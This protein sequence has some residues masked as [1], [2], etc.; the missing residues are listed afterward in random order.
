M[1]GLVPF[2]VATTLS[3]AVATA[4][5]DEKFAGKPRLINYSPASS[6][7]Y[8]SGARAVQNKV[9]QFGGMGKT[10]ARNIIL[11]VGDGMGVST[12]TAARI[13]AGQQHGLPGEE[14]QL[15]FDHFPMSGLART[16][17]TNQQTPDSAGTIT[18]L[19]TGV[20]TRAGMLSVGENA[21]R[22]DCQSQAAN[23]LYSALDLAEI[24]GLATGVVSTARI[25]HATPAAS[26]A[27]SVERNWENDAEMSK[28]ARKQG[29]EDIAS[30][31]I[32]FPQRLK[33]TLQRNAKNPIS[34]PPLNGI[35]VV[36]G[37][38]LRNFIPTEKTIDIGSTTVTGRRKD[39]RNLLDEW[40]R[41]NPS[42]ER[43]YTRAQ[44]LQ[45]KA[46]R[47]L[48]LFSASHM[49]YDAQRRTDPAFAGQPSLADMTGVAIDRLSASKKGF[50]LLVE[51]GRI[52]HAHHASSAYHALSDT[53]A[54]SDAVASAVAKTDPSDTL[55][56]VT[57]DHSHVFTMAGYPVRGN[58]ILGKVKAWTGGDDSKAELALDGN[59][60]PY[61]TLSYANGRGGALL[62]GSADADDRYQYP[63]TPGR[64]R[65]HSI[66]TS[67]A[68]YHQEALVPLPMETHGGEDVPIYARG[69]GAYLISGS[70]EQNVVF[71]VMDYVGGWS[72]SAENVLNAD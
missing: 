43:V 39:G 9:K 26:Y 14:Y 70:N 10:K 11:F 1:F 3:I 7:W 33:T 61:T 69:P 36:L 62:K 46:P 72:E 13:F 5:A 65:L 25:T 58:P 52:D 12:V 64:Q 8:G 68:G 53:V 48:G 54:L 15:A 18:A 22:Q 57:A 31:L 32:S 2:V 44:L 60:Q 23:Q 66:D 19:M 45:S 42:G 4:N 40:Q 63:L 20:K 59:G 35:E 55:I 67:R 71:H 38:G 56:I 28:K 49:A 6:T 30:Q 50:F 27:K 37:G 41:S 51:A 24:A 21:H 34:L 17:N 47:L 16:Y 29:C